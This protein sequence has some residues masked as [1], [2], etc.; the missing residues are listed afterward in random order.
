MVILAK[1]LK[2]PKKNKTDETDDKCTNAVIPHIA[3]TSENHNWK[4]GNTQAVTSTLSLNHTLIIK[5]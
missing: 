1:T 2:L 5:R 3:N 4:A